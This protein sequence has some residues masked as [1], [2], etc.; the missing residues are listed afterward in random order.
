MQVPSVYQNPAVH[1]AERV[2]E[3]PELHTGVHVVPLGE[4]EKQF[5]GR[6]LEIAG[7]PR[8]VEVHMPLITQFPA[9]HVAV[10]VPE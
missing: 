7:S 2:P 3:Y 4:L 6:E 8:H 5:P 1:E 9:L 10:T